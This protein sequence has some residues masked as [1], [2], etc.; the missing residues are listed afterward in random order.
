MTTV[1][2]GTTPSEKKKIYISPSSYLDV[3]N[4][5]IGQKTCAK[6]LVVSRCCL[7]GGLRNVRMC[8]AIVLL[9]HRFVC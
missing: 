3:L 5:P 8:I 6:N 4:A 9:I 1:T 2:R 7:Q